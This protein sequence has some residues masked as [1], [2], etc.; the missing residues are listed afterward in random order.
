MELQLLNAPARDLYFASERESSQHAWKRMKAM[1][2]AWLVV[3]DAKGTPTGV[4]PGEALRDA[5]GAGQH[6][7]GAL[8]V[9]GATVLP[10]SARLTEILRALEAPETGAVLLAEGDQ[11][12]TVVLRQQGVR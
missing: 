10:L 2:A 5:L 7:V 6:L 9:R 11:V 12:R 4:I 3:V 8:P 1:H